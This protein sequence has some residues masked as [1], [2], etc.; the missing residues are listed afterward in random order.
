V[1]YA[2]ISKRVSGFNN[3]ASL[4]ADTKKQIIKTTQKR[5]YQCRGMLL[6]FV[7]FINID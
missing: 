5:F 7:L 6:L 1:F 3:N 4:T 2:I